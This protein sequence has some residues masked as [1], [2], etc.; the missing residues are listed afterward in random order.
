MQ[1]P[2]EFSE[3]HRKIP[4]LNSRRSSWENSKNISE[5]NPRRNSCKK[6]SGGISEEIPGGTPRENFHHELLGKSL[7][8]FVEEF[9][10]RIPG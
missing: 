3:I 1:F 4:G 2:K 10:G 9:L 6:L 8:K 7:E 5:E